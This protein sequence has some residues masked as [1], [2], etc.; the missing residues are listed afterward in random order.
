MTIPTQVSSSLLLGWQGLYWYMRVRVLVVMRRLVVTSK[1]LNIDLR[2][3]RW[4]SHADTQ[5]E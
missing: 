4:T 1:A 2:N 5:E 3:A